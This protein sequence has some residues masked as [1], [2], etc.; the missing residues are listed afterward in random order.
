MIMHV[1]LM[2]FADPDDADE[3]V[4]L[5]ESLAEA[6]PVVRRLVAGP[7]VVTTPNS[8]DVGLVVEV[9][10]MQDLQEYHHHPAHEAA[11]TFFRARRSA[12][13]SIDLAI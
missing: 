3:A 6:I 13:S 2:R 12:I 9:D 1:V 8:Y 11:A 4:R 5:A 10:S 7:T